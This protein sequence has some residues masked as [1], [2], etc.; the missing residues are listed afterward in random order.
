MWF[1]AWLVLSDS[2][3]VRQIVV[4]PGESLR[5]TVVGEGRPVVLIP[6]LFGSAYGF[7]NV[8]PRLVAQGF[9][10]IVVEPLAVG[11]SSRPERVDYSMTAQGERIAAVLDSL[12]ISGA[13]VAAHSLSCSI[14]LRMAT[15]HPGL[16]DGILLIDGGT[17]DVSRS[18]G[19]RRAMLLVPWVKMMGG[20]NTVRRAIRRSLT[21]ASGNP[22][23]VTDELIAQYTEGAARDLDATLKAY[24][25]MARAR[26]PFSIEDRLGRITCPVRLLAG[27]AP[28][29]ELLLAREIDRLRSGLVSFTLEPVAGAGHFI[30]E[31]Q[32]DVIV[33]AVLALSNSVVARAPAMGR[34]S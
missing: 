33:A 12:D 27:Q 24:L 16:V 21:A 23:W 28:H 31:E 34:A 32:P 2:A 30:H 19:F 8:V 10:A 15:R 5:V 18:P 6:G 17:M 20:M 29:P 26:E 14:A 4:A 3:A 11:T 25:R 1:L 13:I 9:R 7:R 22:A